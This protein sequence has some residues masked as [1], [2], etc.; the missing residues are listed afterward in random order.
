[1]SASKYQPRH[2]ETTIQELEDFVQNECE[3][4]VKEYVDILAERCLY[5]AKKRG[6][7]NFGPVQAR[8]VALRFVVLTG[9]DILL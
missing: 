1:M 5:N 7:A 6:A 2:K 3:T 8:E 4:F 9:G